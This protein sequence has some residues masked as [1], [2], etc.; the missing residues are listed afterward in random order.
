MKNI[1]LSIN[2][3]DLKALIKEI[4]LEVLQENPTKQS[5]EL[6]NIIAGSAQFVSE[7]NNK[8]FY[9]EVYDA[10]FNC[11]SKWKSK[12]CT[13]PTCDF[14]TQRPEFH[15]ARCVCFKTDNS[16]Q[17]DLERTEED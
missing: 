16:N 8:S 15:P 9:C 3:E 17:S 4:I 11:K 5:Q 7:L 2:Q 14:C 13:D 10:F 12:K 6:Y 1:A